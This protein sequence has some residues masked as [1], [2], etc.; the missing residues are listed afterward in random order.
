MYTKSSKTV[1]ALALSL[2]AFGALASTYE[3]ECTD[4]PKDKWMSM[5]DVKAKFES[6]G[7]SVKKVK[8]K[9]SCYEVYSKDK[10][11]KKVELFVNPVDASVVGQER[12]D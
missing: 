1:I 7:Y 8:G 4:Q 11:G 9:G 10:D 2:C 6:Q 12:D 5:A 3:G